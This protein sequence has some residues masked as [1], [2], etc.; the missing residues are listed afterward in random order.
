M[1]V[2]LT[3]KLFLVKL[4]G[5]SKGGG[6]KVK[7]NKKKFTICIIILLLI[8]FVLCKNC[9]ADADTVSEAI[10]NNEADGIVGL[11]T[12]GFRLVFLAI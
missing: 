5:K 2:F 7:I 3:Q 10:E 4:E 6:L 12:Y 9:F 8:S 1:L 11:L